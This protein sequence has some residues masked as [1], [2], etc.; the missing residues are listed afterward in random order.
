MT[1][2]RG[3]CLSIIDWIPAFR[4]EVD[5]PLD[6]AGM[7][8]SLSIKHVWFYVTIISF[9]RNR[10]GEIA[11][12]LMLGTLVVIGVTA[13][14]SSFTVKDKKTTSS[15]ASEVTCYDGEKRCG[16]K[17]N[18]CCYN[19]ETHY[20]TSDKQCKLKTAIPPD[21]GPEQPA[22]DCVPK[23]CTEG[24]KKPYWMKAGKY[25][26][27]ETCDNEVTLNTH[28]AS[29]PAPVDTCTSGQKFVGNL[30]YNVETPEQIC[31]AKNGVYVY[32]GQQGKIDVEG[33]TQRW[34]CCAVS[35][36][37]S[38][39]P[40]AGLG[41]AC[42]VQDKRCNNNTELRYQWYGCTGQVCSATKISTFGGPGTLVDCPNG[43]NQ[44]N[45]ESC[46][47]DVTPLTPPGEKCIDYIIESS[48]G[49]CREKCDAENECLAS[50]D[51]TI[52]QEKR[53]CCPKSVP[54][55]PE[56]PPET[57]CTPVQN[58]KECNEVRMG[59]P[60]K[61]FTYKN[62]QCCPSL[63]ILPDG[64]GGAGCTLYTNG[65]CPVGQDGRPFSYY[66]S[67]ATTCP[68][69]QTEKKCYG[70]SPTSCEEMGWSALKESQCN[71][72]TS[73]CELK[74][75]NCSSAY[76]PKFQGADKFS[77]Y[78]S[79]TCVGDKCYS[80]ADSTN[81]MQSTW[82]EIVNHYCEGTD[83]NET[84]P[85]KNVPVAGTCKD[86]A[87]HNSRDCTFRCWDTTSKESYYFDTRATP[88]QYYREDCSVIGSSADTKN[89]DEN[90]K[91]YCDC[92]SVTGPVR[93]IEDD[94]VALNGRFWECKL[95]G[96]FITKEQATDTCISCN[97][98]VN[99]ILGHTNCAIT[100]G[101]STY[102]CNGAQN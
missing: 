13:V 4:P 74:K 81:C 89:L 80:S 101:Y 72:T 43:V 66:K 67:K 92:G 91:S 40:K 8:Q 21:G 69:G 11:T 54:V 28:C 78:K 48:A 65:S 99:R 79:K 55:V 53:F 98:L 31:A 90:L 14:I 75:I 22:N 96:T 33:K 26:N 38:V 88:A 9:M 35:N 71:P 16:S 50:P 7:T 87:S 34:A 41:Y 17:T 85:E 70:T 64:T 19:P 100:K 42:C 12:I 58:N 6:D 30:G 52:S 1:N 68:T 15:R 82:L 77:Y 23:E 3:I 27:S 97:S 2:N 47:S 56:P 20:C 25:Y 93:N 57:G 102:C 61:T 73:D 45:T 60:E 36:A 63:V 95:I 94:M 29:T 51:D 83:L 10:R 59:N 5:R 24:E 18:Y 62:G 76:A 39:C 46:D 84:K 86:T 49:G 32:G 37:N 44:Q